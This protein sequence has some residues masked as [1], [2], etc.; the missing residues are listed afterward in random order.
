MS[1]DS[2]FGQTTFPDLNIHI[3][4]RDYIEKVIAGVFAR[5]PHMS[6][7]QRERLLPHERR[8][9]EDA[10]ITILETIAKLRNHDL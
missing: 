1:D 10:A 3:P 5:Q 8:R 4:L 6:G 7:D 2:D 9:V